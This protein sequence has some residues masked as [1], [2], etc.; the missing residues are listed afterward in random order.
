M[1]VASSPEERP[2][3]PSPSQVAAGAGVGRRAEV[4]VRTVT[5]ATGGASA[6]RSRTWS[7]VEPR[8]GR[9]DG[10]L[11]SVPQAAG[12]R[13]GGVLRSNGAPSVCP[14]RGWFPGH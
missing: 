12:F 4:I 14:W 1:G 11:R 10:A 6:E 13:L 5:M 7:R 8:M 2:P 9:R 3:P